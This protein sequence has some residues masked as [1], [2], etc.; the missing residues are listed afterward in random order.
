MK[1]LEKENSI[2]KQEVEKKFDKDKVIIQSKFEDELRE[3]K[4][5]EESNEIMRERM[6]RLEEKLN[7]VSAG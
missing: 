5:L 6:L 2:L 4:K 7:S 3:K 1:Q